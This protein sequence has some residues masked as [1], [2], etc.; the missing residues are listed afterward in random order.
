MNN[1]GFNY[2]D[3]ELLSGTL[4]A[5]CNVGAK[6]SEEAGLYF[7]WGDTRGY[8][9]EQIRKNKQCS[10]TNYKC[11][12]NEN[13]SSFSKYKKKGAK[14]ELADDAANIYMGGDWHMPTSE[15]IQ[16][17]IDNTTREFEIFNNGISYMT[18]TSKNDITKSIIISTAGCALDDSVD[19]SG[20]YGYIWSSMLNTSF[21]AY[22]QYLYFDLGGA[23]LYSSGIRW[24]GMQVRGVIG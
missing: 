13:S 1:N 17:L 3:L 8:T 7:Q 6:N 20:N 2:I 24:Y 11:G 4:W 15:Q 18:F 21:V 9:I 10:F 23:K 12:S 16:E 22:G 14:L 19:Y 5:T